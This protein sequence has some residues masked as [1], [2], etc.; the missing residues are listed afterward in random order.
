MSSE[1]GRCAKCDSEISVNAERCPECGYEPDSGSIL[2]GLAALIL[3]PIAGFGILM[4]IIIPI[5][6]FSG[7]IGLET[8]G[9]TMLFFGV[10]TLVPIL[11]GYKIAA[12]KEKTPVH[13]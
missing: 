10:V 11:I 8:G 2:G 3:I 6:L 4:L 5:L 9:I 7:G 1:T 12:S 13:D